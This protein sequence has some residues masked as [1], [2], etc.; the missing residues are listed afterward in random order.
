MRRRPA[1]GYM[2]PQQIVNYLGNFGEVFVLRNGIAY[3]IDRMVENP[4]GIWT[5]RCTDRRGQESNAV[6]LAG[7]MWYVTRKE[8]VGWR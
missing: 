8:L 5:A 2:G 4:Q 7:D 6:M 1:P 3:R